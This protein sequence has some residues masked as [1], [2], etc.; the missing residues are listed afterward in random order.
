[1]NFEEFQINHKYIID[2]NKRWRSSPNYFHTIIVAKFEK[3]KLIQT[4]NDKGD[5]Y[6]YD[7]REYSDWKLMEDLGEIPI[8]IC[9]SVLSDPGNIKID[10]DKYW[11]GTDPNRYYPNTCSGSSYIAGNLTIDGVPVEKYNV[12]QKDYNQLLS[13][14]CEKTKGEKWFSVENVWPPYKEWKLCRVV[15][16]SEVEGHNGRIVYFV[17][18]Y[19]GNEG[20]LQ[21]WE[22]WCGDT[23]I[24]L[25]MGKE[26]TYEWRVT[27]WTHLPIIKE[28]CG[29]KAEEINEIFQDKDKRRIHAKELYE[30]MA[31]A[32]V[33]AGNS[34]LVFGPGSKQN[35][36]EIISD[37]ID[38]LEHHCGSS[39]CD[40]WNN[41]TKELIKKLKD[42]RK[43]L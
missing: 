34:T 31:Q 8:A 40:C 2:D 21:K 41:S 14:C 39:D 35:T 26:D 23:N 33:D 22:D 37:A 10:P 32:H 9:P 19:L 17:A 4:M 5:K 25:A 15:L 24:H 30:K 11:T 1:M 42:L 20:D 36:K 18:R 43:V 13:A 7:E 29:I 27:H 12:S 16:H 38:E 3:S 28:D 6:Y